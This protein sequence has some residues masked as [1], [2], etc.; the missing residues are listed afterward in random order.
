VLG[1]EIKKTLK[2]GKIMRIV[3][4]VIV[5]AAIL[6]IGW[7]KLQEYFFFHPW[8][9]LTSYRKLQKLDEFQEIVIKNEE[10][11][12][13]GWFWNIQNAKGPAPLVIFFTG[14]AQNSSNTMYYY[15]ESGKMKD[16]FGGYNLM[17]VDYPGYGMSKGKPSDDS[18]FVAS[19]YV[20]EYAANMQEVDKDKIVIMGYS[21]GTGVA[22]YCASKNA[23]SG[24]I[25][26]APY[27]KALSLYNDSVNS[28]YGPME[29]LAKYRFDSISYA[30]DV[31][32]PTLIFTSKADEVINYKHSLNLAEK[33]PELKD[34]VI[35]E[36]VDHNGYFSRKE[37]L[38]GIRGF[39]EGE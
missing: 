20:F 25:L 30:K 16:V 32:E 9:D 15:Y 39:L 27:D 5:L 29:S 7:N 37:V 6:L 23:A 33:F 31:Q 35:L 4:I 14:N 38:E 10:V 28:F 21:I 3:I 17:I 11:N 18:M 24:L 34:V 8:N 13:S 1:A 22:T 2:K 36:G 12:L 19:N 26:V